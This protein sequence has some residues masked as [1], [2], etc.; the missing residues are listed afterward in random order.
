LVSPVG[1]PV[2]LVLGL[3]REVGDAIARTFQEDGHR[4]L[5]ADP[6]DE[7]LEV[8]RDALEDGAA[9]YHGELHSRLGLRNAITAALEAFGRIDNAVIV[10][11]IEDSDHLL[12]FAQEKFEKALARSARGAALALRVIAE[13]LLDQEDLPQAGVERIR[14]KGTITFILGYASVASMPGRFTETVAQSAILGVMRAGALELAEHGIRVN[15]VVAI[16][17]REERAESWTARRVPLGRAA[18]ADEIAEAARYIASPAAAYM[19]GQSLVLDGG[20]ST[21]SGLLD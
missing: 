16:R 8:A 6:S 5:V 7:R 19:T 12:D 18:Q 3:G 14:Q 1:E 9:T 20:R 10:P 11:E 4:V 17:P 21:L 2:T 15:A 13:R